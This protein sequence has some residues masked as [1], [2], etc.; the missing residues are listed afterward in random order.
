MNE[1]YLECSIHIVCVEPKKKKERR[2]KKRRKKKKNWNDDSAIEKTLSKIHIATIWYTREY[3]QYKSCCCWPFEKLWAVFSIVV[4]VVFTS[5]ILIQQV[6]FLPQFFVF[7]V[8]CGDELGEHWIVGLANI[9]NLLRTL[10]RLYQFRLWFNYISDISSIWSV[11]STSSM[12]QSRY[13]IV[14]IV[15]R[16]VSFE[17]ICRASAML[18]AFGPVE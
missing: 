4:V 6:S 18:L 1:M 2:R 12:R 7:F 8:V 9:S 15:A 3:S 14:D 17:F 16:C 10:H 11:T 5:V 13:S